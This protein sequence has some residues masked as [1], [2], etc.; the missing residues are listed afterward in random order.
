MPVKLMFRYQL[1]LALQQFRK[2]FG[3]CQTLREEIV[4][5]RKIHQEIHIAV[6][7]LF[8]SGYGTE[9]A[10]IPRTELLREGFNDDFSVM[11]FIQQQ[12]NSP[13]RMV[14][15]IGDR[16]GTSRRPKFDNNM[17]PLGF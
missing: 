7:P 6:R 5:A 3:Q 12:K 16:N 15:P 9:H 14:M 2:L 17:F 8:A 4:S 1:H 11:Q 10:N 13:A